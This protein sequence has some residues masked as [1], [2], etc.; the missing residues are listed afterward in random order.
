M[1]P[2]QLPGTVRNKRR[3]TGEQLEQSRTNKPSVEEIL[4]SGLGEA[5]GNESSREHRELHHEP[6]ERPLTRYG[7]VRSGLYS[8]GTSGVREPWEGRFLAVTVGDDPLQLKGT[9]TNHC[10]RLSATGSSAFNGGTFQYRAA[11]LLRY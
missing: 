5:L 1:H 9:V 7:S 8:Y 11:L 10:M 3:T 4:A 2:E 6:P